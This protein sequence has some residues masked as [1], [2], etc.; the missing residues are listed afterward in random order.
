M[1]L[2]GSRVVTRS[3]SMVIEINGERQMAENLAKQLKIEVL[4]KQM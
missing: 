1:N 3:Q 4:K 2:A